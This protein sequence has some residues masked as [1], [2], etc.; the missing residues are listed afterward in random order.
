MPLANPGAE[1]PP[2]PHR[3]DAFRARAKRGADPPADPHRCHAST[4]PRESWCRAFLG[5]HRSRARA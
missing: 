4:C 1:P 5:R 3:A 2:I